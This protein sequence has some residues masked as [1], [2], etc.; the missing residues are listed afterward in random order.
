MFESY[1]LLSVPTPK[2]KMKMVW[3]WFE[4]QTSQIFWAESQI[5]LASHV[6][7][8]AAI[9]PEDEMGFNFLR[10]DRSNNYDF[11]GWK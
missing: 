3:A 5:T 7:R 8:S 1:G 10:S 9:K 4:G 11:T 2:S 6:S